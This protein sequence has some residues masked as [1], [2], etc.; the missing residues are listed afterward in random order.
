MIEM[1]PFYIIGFFIILLALK[2]NKK[3]VRIDIKAVSIF[4]LVMA[5]V[6]AV[7]VIVYRAA[8]ASAPNFFPDVT[9]LYFVWWEDAVF[10]LPLLILNHYGIKMKYQL[11]FI[12]LSS[13]A[14]AGGHLS[15]SL[16]WA[17]FLLCYVYH[18]SYSYGLKYGLGTVMI[19]HVFYDL[20]TTAT[21]FLI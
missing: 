10:V 7:R 12:I 11:P 18:I 2:I 17:A 4:M 9:S 6:T 15:Y 8:G 1:V 14:F 21:T 13:V 5:L 16:S 3:L 20:I 19:C